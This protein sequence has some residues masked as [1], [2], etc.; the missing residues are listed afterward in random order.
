VEEERRREQRVEE[1]GA[2]Q[3]GR[4]LQAGRLVE[5]L[6]AR[7]AVVRGLEF[8]APQQEGEEAGAVRSNQA[9]VGRE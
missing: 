7:L 2:Q 8:L 5:R 6:E 4:A 3:D 9:S 1:R